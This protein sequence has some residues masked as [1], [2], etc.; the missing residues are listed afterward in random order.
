MLID[1]TVTVVGNLFLILGY[2]GCVVAFLAS[3]FVMMVLCYYL[4]ER[5]YLVLGFNNPKYFTRY[6]K[7]EFG[8]IPSRYA[9]QKQKE[10]ADGLETM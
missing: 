3:S 9:A 5:H 1:L 2:M 4:G 7:E 8:M 10:R 6:F